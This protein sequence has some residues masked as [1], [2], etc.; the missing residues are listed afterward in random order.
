[1]T[2]RNSIDDILTR[3][4]DMSEVKYYPG[5]IKGPEPEDDIQSYSKWFAEN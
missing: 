1:M 2:K 4:Y 5:S 3:D